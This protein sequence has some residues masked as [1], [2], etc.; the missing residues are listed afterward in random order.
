MVTEIYFSFFDSLY[1]TP[2]VSSDIAFGCVVD[3]LLLQ[4]LCGLSSRTQRTQVWG[5]FMRQ[6][7]YISPLVVPVLM[8]S[9]HL[10]VRHWT[11]WLGLV[12]M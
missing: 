7:T 2:D 1:L 11:S 9:V 3:P 5:N 10:P 6:F 12:L 4:I 8:F